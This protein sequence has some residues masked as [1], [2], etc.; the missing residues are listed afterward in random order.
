M[1]SQD[2]RCDDQGEHGRRLRT[3]AHSHP[4]GRLRAGMAQRVALLP[5]LLGHAVVGAVGTAPR[6]RLH[7]PGPRQRDPPR[8][9]Q[10]LL[11]VSQ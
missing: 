4:H 9:C 11:Q 6:R 3:A 8:L 2:G 10:D 1:P 5:L 7:H